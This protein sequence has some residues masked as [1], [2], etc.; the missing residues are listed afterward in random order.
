[1][2]KTDTTPSAGDN[3][4]HVNGGQLLALIERIEQVEVEIADLNEGK[5]EI[6]KEAR[7]NGFDAKIIK[8]LVGRRRM[9]PDKRA[10]EDALMELYSAALGEA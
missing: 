7:G 8:K 10:E 9:A 2:I 5:K 6:Y 1:V 3:S 4:S